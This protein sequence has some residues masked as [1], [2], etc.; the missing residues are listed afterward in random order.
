[1]ARVDDGVGEF[2]PTPIMEWLRAAGGPVDGYYQSM[3]VRV[4]ADLT[5]PDLRAALQAVLDRHDT[6]RMRLDRPSCPD[7]PWRLDVATPGSVPA[8][9]VLTRVPVD[10]DLP[11]ADRRRI[12]ADH[13]A[14]AQARL[15]PA[16]RVMVQAVWFDAGPRHR[17]RLLLAA[18]H[19]AVDGVSWRILLPDLAAAWAAVSAGGRP[20]L[21]PVATSCRRWSALLAEEA[22]RPA[23]SAELDLW[24]GMLAHRPATGRPP[25]PGPGA[26]H[27]PDAPRPLAQ[28]VPAER[29]G[30]CCAGCR[31]RSTPGSTRCC[32]PR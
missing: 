5:E 7:G 9:A 16:G 22:T 32:W 17:G 2:A 11:E 20:E 15:A 10:P 28:T 13:A 12:V 19:L 6:L 1:M 31:T 23:R 21:A 4:P 3:V 18:H 8:A 14:A 24:R 29:R 25:R 30:R 27:R 26:R